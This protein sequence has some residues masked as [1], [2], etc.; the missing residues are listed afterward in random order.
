[1]TS[2]LQEGSFMKWSVEDQDFYD[3]FKKIIEQSP[4]ELD[5][6]YDYNSSDIEGA[7]LLGPDN[8]KDMEQYFKSMHLENIKQTASSLMTLV[9]ESIPE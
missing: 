5:K 6:Q 3:S 4:F 2:T 8:K 7:Y 9:E 1:M